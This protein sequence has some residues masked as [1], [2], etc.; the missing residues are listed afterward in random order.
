MKIKTRCPFCGGKLWFSNELVAKNNCAP[1]PV[2]PGVKFVTRPPEHTDTS[3]VTCESC[4]IPI[5]VCPS[6][7]ATQGQTRCS[8]GVWFD[9]GRPNGLHLKETGTM[10]ELIEPP[11][12][13]AP[14]RIMQR[15]SRL[16]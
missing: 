15:A 4:G 7:T 2:F 14:S 5:P 12:A 1:G 8:C 9:K 11:K 10:L 16:S 13:A 6:V 3:S